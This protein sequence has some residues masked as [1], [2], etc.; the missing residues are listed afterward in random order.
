MFVSEEKTKKTEKK[1][2]KSD[3]LEGER[4]AMEELEDP[5]LPDSYDRGNLC[6]T[7]TKGDKKPQYF[8][9]RNRPFLQRVMF[10]FI[11][12]IF[13]HVFVSHVL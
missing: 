4:R 8:V 13:C 11:W 1:Y 2:L 12:S 9:G 7:T 5:G 6:S 3:V 10:F